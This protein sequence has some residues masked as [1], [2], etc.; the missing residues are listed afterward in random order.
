M[1]YVKRERP[2]RALCLSGQPCV[3]L[4]PAARDVTFSK[5]GEVC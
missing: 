2:Q 3:A 1:S 5:M 4:D